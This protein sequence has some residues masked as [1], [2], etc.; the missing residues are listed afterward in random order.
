MFTTILTFLKEKVLTI[1]LAVVLLIY[2]GYLKYDIMAT[3][4]RYDAEIFELKNQLTT[5]E[6]QLSSTV[7]K[8]D[9]LKLEN[10][11]IKINLE[12]FEKLINEKNKIIAEMEEYNKKEINK[13][14]NLKIASEKEQQK[15]D[16]VSKESS[17]SILKD[18]NDMLTSN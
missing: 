12:S 7:Q 13:I 8:Y 16:I 5:K 9:S 14:L 6:V 11:R 15:Y 1:L 2:I 3:E 18:I 10:D 4:K 17:D